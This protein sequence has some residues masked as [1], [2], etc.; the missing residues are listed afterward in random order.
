MINSQ[1]QAVIW[2]IDKK[3]RD[4][5]YIKN[6]RPISLLNVDAKIASK[7]LALRLEKAL[8]EIIGV[9]QYVYVEGR[10]IFDAVRTID[11]VMEYTKIKQVLGLIIAFDFK[12]A[13]DS[14]SWSFLIK[15]LKSFRFGE[16]FIRW[17]SV[18]HFNISSCVMNNGFSAQLF[19]VHR[20]VREGDPLSAYLF[21]IVLEL[22]LIMI[23]SDQD[24]SGIRIVDK[25]I[26]PGPLPMI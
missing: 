23:W 26:K 24:I 21:I 22:L 2:L 8:P 19:E 10:T 4:R 3:D 5:R 13:F 9:D 20:V 16:S 11:V 18:L 25:E 17:V 14:L 12:E 1:K 7:A 15:A 6:W